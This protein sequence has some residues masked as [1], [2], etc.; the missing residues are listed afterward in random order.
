MPPPGGKP[1]ARR[2]LPDMACG[3]WVAAEA[4]L[5]EGQADCWR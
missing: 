5:L 1:L 3:T 2:A 4:C